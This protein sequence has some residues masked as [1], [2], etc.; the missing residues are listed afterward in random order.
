MERT[1]FLDASTVRFEEELA[2]SA[3]Y[4]GDP[5]QMDAIIKL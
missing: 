2:Q 3:C 1:V 5:C 4:C